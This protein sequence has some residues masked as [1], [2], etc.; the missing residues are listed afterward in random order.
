MHPDSG[1]H[2]NVRS[3]WICVVQTTFRLVGVRHSLKGVVV[4]SI[5]VLNTARARRSACYSCRPQGSGGVYLSIAGA[6][7]L[8]GRAVVTSSVTVASASVS[9][10]QT[11]CV[12]QLC[13]VY[14]VF[15]V[16]GPCCFL[17]RRRLLRCKTERWALKKPVRVQ[18]PWGVLHPTAR[19]AS[20]RSTKTS[21]SAAA[22]FL[23]LVLCVPWES[24]HIRAPLVRASS[25]V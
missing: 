18:V 2:E 22:S 17:H 13:S 11:L 7:F 20:D 14:K 23:S 4:F 1:L 9:L 5:R 10:R 6:V 24:P 16:R 25:G 8:L 19:G 12:F 15:W 3:Q 21:T